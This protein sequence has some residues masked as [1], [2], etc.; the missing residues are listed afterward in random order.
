MRV[1]QQYD[2]ES[3]GA[4]KFQQLCQAL[5]V[6]NHPDVQC[7]PVGMPDGGRDASSVEMR[8]PDAVIY[9]VKFRRPTP[10]K[11]ATP[12]EICDW[13][14]GHIASE[15]PK[16]EALAQRGAY[17]YVVMTNAQCSSHLD[18]GTRDRMQRWLD[19]NMPIPS[20]VWWR[21]DID[22]R[23]DAET[24]IKRSYGLLRDAVGLAEMLGVLP[25]DSPQ[26]ETIR[27]AR[28]DRRV[29]AL[30]KYLRHQYE[31]DRI[32]KFKQAELKPELLDVFVDVPV[33]ASNQYSDRATLVYEFYPSGQGAR[34][35]FERWN[36]LISERA[37][38]TFAQSRSHSGSGKPAATLLLHQNSQPLANK[39]VLEGAP[40]Q[41]KS[42]VSQYVCQVHRARLLGLEDEVERF[43]A[44]H[45]SSPILLPFH[46][47]L[48]DLSTWLKGEDPFN[49][50]NHQAPPQWA[51]SLE[52]FLA[53]QVRHDSGGMAFDVSD[54]DAVTSATPVILML[55]GLDE[56]PDLND[57]KHVVNAVNEAATR[58][59]FS[60]PFLLTVVTSRPSAFARTPGFSKKDFLYLQM[61]DLP[62]SLVLEY[63]DGWLRS[64]D[65]PHKEAYDIRKVLGEKLGQ[66]HIVDLARNPMQLA[67]L[68]WLVNRK[69]LSLPDKRTALYGA[70]MDTFL[71]REAEKSQIVRDERDLILELHGYV[72]WE[73][74]CQAEVGKSRGS[75]AET[76]L[77]ALLKKYLSKEDYETD[78][79][80]QLFS[81]MT[82]RVMVLTS[83]VQNTFEFEVQPLREYFA[84]R[85]LHSTA[86]TSPPGA[87]RSGTRSDRFE[88]LLRNPYWF[89]VTRFYAG[90]S[91]KGELANLVD[92][93]EDVIG[94]PEFSLISYPVRVA[95]TLLRDQVFAQ[96]PKSATRALELVTSEQALHVLLPSSSRESESMAFAEGYGSYDLVSKMESRVERKVN[97]GF[98]DTEAAHILSV[99]RS[100]RENFDWWY[101]KWQGA[102]SQVKKNHWFRLIRPLN[103]LDALE[104]R[105]LSAIC[106][107]SPSPRAFW[108]TVIDSA[109]R[110]NPEAGTPAYQSLS[111]VLR[112]A[113]LDVPPS[114]YRPIRTTYEVVSYVTSRDYLERRITGYFPH[115]DLLGT[116]QR[117]LQS[118]ECD[119]LSQAIMLAVRELVASAE[120]A[121]NIT[122]WQATHE[123]L[124]EAYGEQNRA[125]LTFALEAGNVRSGS[126]SRHLAGGLLDES[127]PLVLRTRYARQRRN[128]TDWWVEQAGAVASKMDAWFVLAATLSW[129]TR[130]T[131][132]K[133][134]RLL[135]RWARQ[136]SVEDLETLSRYRRL[137]R[138]G[139]ASSDGSAIPRAVG[140]QTLF[141]LALV[142]PSTAVETL[143]KAANR[144]S[145]KEISALYSS[146]VVERLSFSMRD[147]AGGR[148]QELKEAQRSAA[149]GFTGASYYAP[150]R[151]SNAAAREI[152]QDPIW[153]PNHLVKLADQ[154]LTGEVSRKATPLAAVAS[155]DDWFED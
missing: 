45:Q 153:V 57:R 90:F 65:V 110:Y 30:M 88:A 133:V 38:A 112:D 123:A 104:P 23:L 148:L 98:P 71:D 59:A 58:I 26:H 47:D 14:E 62:L 84:A 55:D 64:R 111:W 96:R 6:K 4:E 142:S 63:T 120:I 128:D 32:V 53:A 54:L 122:L 144:C 100:P 1:T 121:S 107:S 141:I 31:R 50:T 9:Q 61:T 132:I 151:I 34:K 11:L 42:T 102:K 134:V 33:I 108:Q 74:H 77:K 95:A 93:I 48:R 129:A 22:R 97:A 29:A 28:S 131:I 75:I 12:D 70:Y 68:L 146:H 145:D 136:F 127:K 152:L 91:D 89:N 138:S 56:V 140:H 43:P 37:R 103:F 87:E 83:R 67:I 19:E 126:V 143:I 51:D 115:D 49:I 78:L 24:D 41:G 86:K 118:D 80:D 5:L 124:V 109:V 35:A 125:T 135:D 79:V 130:E 27:L 2:Y 92:L 21:D 52:S 139:S 101:Q 10:N 40:G 16:V 106:A 105:D 25:L 113:T 81:G 73:L 99:N 7:F 76:K 20:Q 36:G 154:W 69:G 85:Y 8:I 116:L 18:A 15:V 147:V 94:D 3:L 72:A 66:P 13:L 119:R 117:F 44:E 137:Q 150:H 155:R 46:V 17:R 114:F 149:Q 82:Q 60:C 39:F